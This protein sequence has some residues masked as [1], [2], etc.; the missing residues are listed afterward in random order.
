[1]RLSG[2]NLGWRGMCVWEEV[3]KPIGNDGRSK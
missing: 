3:V 2:F 1:M